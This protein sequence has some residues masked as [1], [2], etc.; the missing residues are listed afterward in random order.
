MTIIKRW[1]KLTNK[2]FKFEK[3]EREREQEQG[4]FW[5]QGSFGNRGTRGQGGFIFFIRIS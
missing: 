4:G 5:E 3:K 2:T 1:Y